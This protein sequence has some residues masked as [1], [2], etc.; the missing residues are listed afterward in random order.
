M[1]SLCATAIKFLLEV[2]TGVNMILGASFEVRVSYYLQT[3]VL[4]YIF[5]LFKNLVYKNI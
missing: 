2:L 5:S 4:K 3:E 1:R